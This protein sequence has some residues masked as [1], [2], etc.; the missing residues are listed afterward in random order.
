M[1]LPSKM[2]DVQTI[3][4]GLKEDDYA[5]KLEFGQLTYWVWRFRWKSKHQDTI[6]VRFP[7]GDRTDP[8]WKMEI[9]DMMPGTPDEAAV[10]RRLMGIVPA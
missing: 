6:I 8:A 2:E 1:A 9:T 10:L 5:F 7:P 3:L 4:L